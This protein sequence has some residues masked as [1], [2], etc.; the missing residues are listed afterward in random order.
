M[1]RFQK[2]EQKINYSTCL[3]KVNSYYLLIQIT[4]GI[5]GIN[6]KTRLRTAFQSITLGAHRRNLAWG[7]TKRAINN[8]CTL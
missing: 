2:G 8:S 5:L 6:I 4:K 3:Y 7:K 1:N